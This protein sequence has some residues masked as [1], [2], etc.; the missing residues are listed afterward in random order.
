MDPQSSDLKKNEWAHCY[1][2]FF[3]GLKPFS[4]H[5]YLYLFAAIRLINVLTF[6]NY[7]YKGLSNESKLNPSYLS[8]NKHA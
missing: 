4:E 2:V 5:G 8:F 1:N 3:S 7:D 6:Y